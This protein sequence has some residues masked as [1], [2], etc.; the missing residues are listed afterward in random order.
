MGSSGET[1]FDAFDF[2][3]AFTNVVSIPD[4]PDNMDPGNLFFLLA[5]VYVR[6]DPYMSVNFSGLHLHGGSPP[7]IPKGMTVKG[8]E[9]RCNGVDYP[10][11]VT[12]EGEAQYPLVAAPD[13]KGAIFTTPEMRHPE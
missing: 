7:V 8:W 1:H 12:L 4:L 3:G 11:S 9:T 5:G 2:S 13:N 10:Q 6:L